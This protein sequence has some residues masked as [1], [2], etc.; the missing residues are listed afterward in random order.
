MKIILTD[1][2]TIEV[3]KITPNADGLVIDVAATLIS[4]IE[5]QI[6]H[7][8]IETIICKEG[9]TVF[10]KYDHQQLDKM[11]KDTA[12]VHIYTRYKILTADIDISSQLSEIQNAILSLQSMQDVQNAAIAEIGELVSQNF[13]EDANENEEE[14]T[15]DGA[16]LCNDGEKNKIVIDDV[17]LLWKDRVAA[18]IGEVEVTED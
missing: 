3:N 9:E 4:D 18:A 16:V 12:G 10:A 8:S 11:V 13:V 2:T 7:Q 17:P 6:T 5:Q 14:V 15:V 1:N